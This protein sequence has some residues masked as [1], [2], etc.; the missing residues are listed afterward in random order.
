MNIYRDADDGRPYLF[1]DWEETDNVETD[2]DGVSIRLTSNEMIDQVIGA[3][4]ALKN[5]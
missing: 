1:I 3:L 4:T 2:V 5:Q